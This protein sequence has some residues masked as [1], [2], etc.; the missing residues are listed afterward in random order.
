[1]TSTLSIDQYGAN[2][3]DDILASEAQLLF[4]ETNNDYSLSPAR[5]V[6]AEFPRTLQS[7]HDTVLLETDIRSSIKLREEY[8]I[9]LR[10]HVVDATP[11]ELQ[12]RLLDIIGVMDLLRT[13]TVDVV[14]SIVRWRRGLPK[15]FPWKGPRSSTTSYIIKISSDT[16]FIAENKILEKWLGMSLRHNP[17]FS[18]NYKAR[19]DAQDAQE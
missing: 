12:M 4:A 7:V 13:I 8:L 15:P 9:R 6:A 5:P 2:A 3:I 17:F 11:D 10:N 16:D 18:L 14:E 1:M 19:H